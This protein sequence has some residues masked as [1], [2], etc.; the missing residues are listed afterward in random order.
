MPDDLDLTALDDE[1]KVGV[2]V[3]RVLGV[4]AF[5][6]IAVWWIYVFAN[7]SS[8]DHPDEFA[9]DD[10]TARAE[11]VCAARQQ[12]ILDLPNA[13]TVSSPEERADLVERAT[14]E[15]EQMV[16]EL[17]AL[18]PPATTKGAEIVPQWLADYELYLQDRRDWTEILRSGDDP[19][20]LVSANA[21]G[22]RVTDVLTTFAEVNDMANCGPSG[23][24]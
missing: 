3:W 24:V 20:F 11:A 6:A 5:I 19:P 10:W 2:T 7:G 16:R 23:D 22:A 9:D 21:N 13:A 8:V 18:G 4:L 17:D 15:L 1:P 14:A 12:A